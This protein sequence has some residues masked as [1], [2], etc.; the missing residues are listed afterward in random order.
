[1]RLER[2]ATNKVK[3]FLTFDDL[4]ERGLTKE[5]LWRDRPRVHQLFRDMVMEAEGLGFQA[6]RSLS[7]E[8]FALPA[9]GMVVHISKAAAIEDEADYIEMDITVDERHELFYQFTDL[10]PVLQ[11]ADMLYQL[12]VR[13]GQ[14]L[15]MD[16]YYY[17]YFPHRYELPLSFDRFIA[18]ASEYG[19]ACPFSPVAV[20]EH[21]KQ[22]IKEGA[23]KTLHETFHR[24]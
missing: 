16:A 24:K 3:V 13:G 17:L 9:Q 11:L 20:D 7:V 14:L 21:G 19:E 4:K 23:V 1:M 22:L 8:V 6:D 18:I 2:I 10:E 12:G 15:S 5:D